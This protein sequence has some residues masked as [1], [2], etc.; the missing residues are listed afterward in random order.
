MIGFAV[1]CNTK[2]AFAEKSQGGVLGNFNQFGKFEILASGAG[3]HLNFLDFVVVPFHFQTKQACL[4]LASNP[5]AKQVCGK[6]SNHGAFC[7]AW[8]FWVSIL[9]PSSGVGFI[10]VG[11]ILVAN[12]GLLV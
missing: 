2:L 8:P 6:L 11:L 4:D 12:R 7:W 1:S 10:E 3:F 5:S 9:F